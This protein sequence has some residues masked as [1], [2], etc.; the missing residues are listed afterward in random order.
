MAWSP[1]FPL[2]TQ[3]SSKTQ[4]N[5]V[6]KNDQKSEWF[7]RASQSRFRRIWG[8]QRPQK[9]SKNDSKMILGHE[10]CRFL[11]KCIFHRP[12]RC[13][14]MF[15]SLKKHQKAPKFFQISIQK[16][17]CEKTSRDWFFNDLGVPYG[18]PSGPPKFY[19]GPLLEPFWSIWSPVRG[20]MPFWRWVL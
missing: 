7:K 17:M 8:A 1:G 10:K 3:K 14:K 4:K 6:Q 13:E 20:Q 11:E 15:E 18:G 9:A 2:G 5:E 16:R 12:C 19:Y